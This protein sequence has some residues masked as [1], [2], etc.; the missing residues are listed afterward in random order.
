MFWVL[1]LHVNIEENERWGEGTVALL[2][3]LVKSEVIFKELPY[4]F[5]MGFMV[6]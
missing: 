5:V 4:W 6:Y 2:V 3:K 1:P